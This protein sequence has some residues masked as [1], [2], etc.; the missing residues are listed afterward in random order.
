MTTALIGGTGLGS[1][2][3]LEIHREHAVDTPYGQPS[4]PIAE[5]SYAGEP[6]LFLHRHGGGHSGTPIPPHL[7]N[8][9]ANLWALK[10]LG[11]HRIVAANAV[12]GIAPALTSGQ[13]VVPS[14]LIDYTWGREHTFDDGSRGELLHVDFTEPFDGPLRGA[15]LRAA[16]A[17]AVAAYDGGVVGVVQGPRLETAAE[18]R[19]MARDGCDMV[20]MTA[21]PE[22]SLARE[23]ALPYAAVCMVVNTAAGL[24]E[25]SITLD[26]I[27]ATLENETQLLGRL[28]AA[29]LAERV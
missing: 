12:G 19:R 6:L 29:V 25:V 11:A 1:L 16:R 13:L 8:Y 15:L 18:V 24:S 27:R 2:A 4:M 3:E 10:E 9:R 23:L 22:A 28:L 5:G 17:A 20:G 14:Q 7:V 21:M 26:A